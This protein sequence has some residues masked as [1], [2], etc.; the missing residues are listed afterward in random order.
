MCDSSATTDA[1]ELVNERK[2]NHTALREASK[3]VL[4]M[5]IKLGCCI[6]Y[7]FETECNYL[8][9]SRP[10]IIFTIGHRQ[11]IKC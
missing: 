5:S 1:C 9:I 8:Q 7:K 4:T 3:F 11:C 6:K 2:K 10:S